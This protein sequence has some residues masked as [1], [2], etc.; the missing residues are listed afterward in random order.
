MKVSMNEAGE[1]MVC[2]MGDYFTMTNHGNGSVTVSV[3]G[4]SVVLGVQQLEDM[5]DEVL[6]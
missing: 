5:L 1:K 4:R 6:K 3:K 2:T